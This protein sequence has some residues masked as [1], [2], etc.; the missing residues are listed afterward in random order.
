MTAPRCRSSAPHPRRCIQALKCNTNKCPTGI[1]T[2]DPALAAGLVPED[3]ALRVYRYHHTTVNTAL[4][5]V[6]AIGV[7]LPSDVRS[8]HIM[9][10]VS[11]HKVGLRQQLLAAGCWLLAR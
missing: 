8:D 3:K 5:L 4:E 9:R 2:Q 7:P 1:A 11:P 6:G 10:R